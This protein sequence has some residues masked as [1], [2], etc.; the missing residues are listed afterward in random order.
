MDHSVIHSLMVIWP[1]TVTLC[2]QETQSSI[3]SKTNEFQ[4]QNNESRLNVLFIPTTESFRWLKEVSRGAS[5]V[6]SDSAWSMESRTRRWRPENCPRDAPHGEADAAKTE[7]TSHVG[8]CKRR[9]CS[10]RFCS[11]RDTAA[12]LCGSSGNKQ[13]LRLSGLFLT[14]PD[15]P[16]PPPGAV[17]LAGKTQT[18]ITDYK[19]TL[20]LRLHQ[21]ILVE[22][23]T[24]NSNSRWGWD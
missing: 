13:R 21:N 11:D 5:P 22:Y 12:A 17:C 8:T 18:V 2:P 16:P 4:M 7:Q 24:T 6:M 19:I 14:A 9:L 3:Y 23:A 1:L 15:T 20:N 10:W